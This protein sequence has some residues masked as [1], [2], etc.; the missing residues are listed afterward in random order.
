MENLKIFESDAGRDKAVVH[1]VD[2]VDGPSGK[3]TCQRK[4]RRSSATVSSQVDIV[5]ARCGLF[6]AVDR[7]R[8]N[9]VGCRRQGADDNRIASAAEKLDLFNR[10]QAVFAVIDTVIDP[11]KRIRPLDSRSIPDASV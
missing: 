5:A 4:E 9:I 3:A 10:P 1:H 8:R 2:A 7:Y 11:D 6:S